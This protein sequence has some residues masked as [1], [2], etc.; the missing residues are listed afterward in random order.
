MIDHYTHMPY[1]FDVPMELSMKRP[2]HDEWSFKEFHKE[3]L[4]AIAEAREKKTWEDTPSLDDAIILQRRQDDEFMV[5]GERR[6]YDHELVDKVGKE[7]GFSDEEWSTARV[8]PHQMHVVEKIRAHFENEY[9]SERFRVWIM[10]NSPETQRMVQ[11]LM[12]EVVNAPFPLVQKLMQLINIYHLC[13][14]IASAYTIP[15]SELYTGIDDG[16]YIS[17]VDIDRWF[18]QIP[19]EIAGYRDI[20]YGGESP[21]EVAIEMYHE[22]KGSKDMVQFLLGYLTDYDDEFMEEFD[23]ER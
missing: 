13:S 8:M 21:L 16:M 22:G 18:I 23:I 5:R 10:N 12:N 7:L 6:M 14:S 11:D 9:F 19:A 4:A 2:S 17:A 15:Y 3:A 1:I 20:H